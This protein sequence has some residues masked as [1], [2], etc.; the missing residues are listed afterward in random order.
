MLVAV[1]VVEVRGGD[2][3]ESGIAEEF[4]SLVVERGGSWS[5][6]APGPVRQGCLQ[7]FFL[8]EAVIAEKIVP[9][10]FVNF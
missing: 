8:P 10:I 4:Q 2:E 7:V 9:F 3:A 1:R 6:V 5:L